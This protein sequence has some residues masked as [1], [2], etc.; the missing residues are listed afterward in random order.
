MY[1]TSA[2]SSPVGRLTL[3]GD[4]HSL[5]GLWIEN[6]KHFG[7][8]LHGPLIENGDLPVLKQTKD[9]LDRYFAGEKPDPAELFLAPAGSEFRRRVWDLLCEIPYGQV[10]TYG[11]IAGRIAH[12]RHLKTMSGQAVGGAVGHNPI[13]ILIPC[14]RVIGTNGSL[15]GYA[16]GIPAKL[17]LLEL[18]GAAVSGLP[19]SDKKQLTARKEKQDDK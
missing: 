18:E 8:T 5:T 6:Q 7:S 9:W 10:I 16:G 11:D 3:A 13:A 15:T 2:Y 17:K 4:E 1:Y 14:H 19:G 12:E